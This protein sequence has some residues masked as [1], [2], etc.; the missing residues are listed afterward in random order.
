MCCRFTCL[1]R[2]PFNLFLT[3]E[4]SR[5]YYETCFV[6]CALVRV[7]SRV[8]MFQ[9]LTFGRI[10]GVRDITK[11]E[12]RSDPKKHLWTC[13]LLL[14]YMKDGCE[15][16]C[17]ETSIVGCP[18]YLGIVDELY[19][20]NRTCLYRIGIPLLD[21]SSGKTIEQRLVEPE[22]SRFSGRRVYQAFVKDLYKVYRETFS[23]NTNVPVD[24]KLRPHGSRTFMTN[25][26]QRLA[27]SGLISPAAMESFEAQLGH[28][29][30]SDISRQR[31]LSPNYNAGIYFGGWLSRNPVLT[32]TFHL[33][34]TDARYVAIN[35]VLFMQLCW[36]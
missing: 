12:N 2:S 13:V 7:G 32:G 20:L 26:Y 15:V 29:P 4:G 1:T 28:S 21:L 5:R 30:E 35:C 14:G 9:D 33:P 3:T 31:Y 22:L 34:Q 16:D 19:Y 11:E 27:E 10:R 8:G 17:Y 36:Y 24:C 18:V 25:K 23:R 6:C